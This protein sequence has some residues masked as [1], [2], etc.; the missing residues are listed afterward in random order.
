LAE[1]GFKLSLA[2]DKRLRK[3]LG[4]R[5]KHIGKYKATT[6]SK[7]NLPIAPNLLDRQFV[8]VTAPNQ[9]WVADITYVETGDGWLYLAAVK[10]LFTCK[11]VG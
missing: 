5:C 11:I 8:E 2:A 6:D 7:H 10:D 4:L 3:R 1:T 9:T